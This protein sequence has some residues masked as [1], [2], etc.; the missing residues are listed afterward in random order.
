MG[1]LDDQMFFSID[2][3]AFSLGVVAPK[4]EDEMIPR[5]GETVNDGVGKEFPTLVLM[6]ACLMGP[7]GEGGVEQED[8]LL[9]PVSQVA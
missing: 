7:D 3:G 8:A 6:R 5:L 4:D 2:E 9:G 1:G